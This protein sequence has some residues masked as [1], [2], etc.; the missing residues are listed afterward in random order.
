VWGQPARIFSGIVLVVNK[1]FNI[2]EPD[3]AVFGQKDIQ[4]FLIL[5]QMVRE[6]NHGET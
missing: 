1:L 4:Q 3:I 5:K 2:I 6:F